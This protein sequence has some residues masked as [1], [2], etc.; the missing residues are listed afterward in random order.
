ESPTGEDDG[1]GG[2][3][4]QPWE[5]VDREHDRPVGR[6]RADGVQ[7]P[8]RDRALLRRLPRRLGAKQRDLERVTLWGRQPGEGL[9][10]DVGE[11]VDEPC[12]AQLRLRLARPGR[13]QPDPARAGKIDPGL[14]QRGL[15]DPGLADEDQGGALSS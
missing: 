9:A 14:P 7:R 4:V 6:E 8:E 15:P 1:I 12:E 13:E 10:V 2:W 3:R 11:E 5:I